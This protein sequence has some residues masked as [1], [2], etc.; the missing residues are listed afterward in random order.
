MLHLSS[1]VTIRYGL[2]NVNSISI[3]EAKT[4]EHVVYIR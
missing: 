2:K 3:D 4:L 1:E